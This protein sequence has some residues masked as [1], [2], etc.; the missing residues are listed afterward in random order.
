MW[1]YC[2]SGVI[3]P[4]RLGIEVVAP[5]LGRKGQNASANFKTNGVEVNWK[6]DKIEYER[7]QKLRFFHKSTLNYFISIKI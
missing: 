4:I 2:A 7:I 1:N 3:E 5:S 6:I